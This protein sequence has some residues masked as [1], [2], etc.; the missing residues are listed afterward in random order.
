MK[1]TILLAVL[2]VGMTSPAFAVFEFTSTTGSTLGSTVFM[3]ST[4]VK[5]FA[6]ADAASYTCASKHTAGDT[7]FKATHDSAVI[8][9][10]TKDDSYKGVDITDQTG[11]MGS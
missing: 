5:L 7:V 11:A 2:L 10:S 6:V 9:D 3:T 4:N 1:K 8:D